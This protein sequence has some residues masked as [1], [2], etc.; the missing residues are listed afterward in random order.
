MGDSS[1]ALL[2]PDDLDLDNLARRINGICRSATFDLTYRV[3]QL[4]IQELFVG[5]PRLWEKQGT[6]SHSYRALAARGDLMLSASALCRAVGVYVLV[7]RLG[8]RQ[9]WRHLSASHFQEVLSLDVESRTEVLTSAEE[10]RWPVS[11]VRAEVRTLKA[12]RTKGSKPYV[13]TLKRLSSRLASCQDLLGSINL[14]EAEEA[15][16]HALRDAVD[17]LY[18]RMAQ[19]N[20]IVE[21]RAFATD[22]SSDVRELIG[23]PL[24]PRLI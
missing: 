4:I 20:A 1:L 15:S 9:R 11:R 19:L 3:G 21:E 12:G 18:S 6:R 17:G 2:E 14:N 22:G 13:N 23:T 24:P 10:N 16:L 5:C 7:E 8:G